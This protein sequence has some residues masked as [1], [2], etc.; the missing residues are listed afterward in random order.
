MSKYARYNALWRTSSW[1]FMTRTLM[2]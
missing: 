1:E 2:L